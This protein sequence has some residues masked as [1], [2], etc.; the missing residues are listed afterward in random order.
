MGWRYHPG[1]GPESSVVKI[2]RRKWGQVDENGVKFTSYCPMR[3]NPMAQKGI[4]RCHGIRY[5]SRSSACATFPLRS[6]LHSAEHRATGDNRLTCFLDDG[7]RVRTRSPPA[8]ARPKQRCFCDIVERPRPRVS[9]ASGAL[10][11]R[12]SPP[13]LLLSESGPVAPVARGRR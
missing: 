12:A 7:D 2:V 4:A 9:L 3:K 11:G 10:I 5:R 8:T 6:S 1:A 13:R